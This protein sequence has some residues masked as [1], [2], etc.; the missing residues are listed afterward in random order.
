MT[1]GKKLVVGAL[2][3]ASV[4]TVQTAYAATNQVQNVIDESYVQP[5]YV[6]GYSLS[7]EQKNQ[8]LALLN[9]NNVKDKKVKTLNTTAYAAIMNVADDP[10]IQLYSSVRIQK[11]GAKESLT[12]K[13]VT[14]EN[15]QKVTQ[16]M[17]RN[18][19]IT[20]GIE[21]ANIQVASPIPV[22]GESALAGLY[23][24]LEKNGAKVPEENKQLAQEELSALS[25]INAENAG[26]AGYDAD[27]LNVALTD[28]KAAIAKG[29]NNLTEDQIR[30]IVEDTLKNYNL[31]KVITTNQINLI[32]NFASHLSNSG[33]ITNTQFVKTLNTLKNSIVS[34]AKGTFEHID[35][36]FNAS[37][38]IEAGKGIWQQ[39]VEF[40]KQFVGG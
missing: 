4:L 24:S 3:L 22:T 25:G 34:N 1:Y 11:L 40:F 31:T 37:Q 29:G 14:P 15:I 21:H 39:I 12:V 20:L 5:D 8:T 6:L 28:I 32:V 33:V 9:Y 2:V 36:N 17:Y 26:K 27:K 19:A 30:K 7:P 16:D 18:A 13:I 38:A 10:G 23:Y 35:L